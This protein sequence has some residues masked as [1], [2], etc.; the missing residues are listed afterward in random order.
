MRLFDVKNITSRRNPI[1]KRFRQVASGNAPGLLL[2]DGVHLIE[3]AEHA[4]VALRDV[5][6]GP[7]GLDL[8]GVVQLLSRVEAAGVAVWS[9]TDEVIGAI[10]PT[11]SPAGLVALAARPAITLADAF[12]EAPQMVLVAV[13]V[14]DPGN[15]G[16]M[17]R[18]AEA[19]GATA[20]VFA[21]A[22]ADPFGWKALRGSMGSTFRLPVVAATPAQALT[23]ARAAGLRLIATTPR[24]QRS[25]YE[26]DLRRPVA[27][28]VGAEGAGLPSDVIEAADEIVR[29]PM[30]EPVES[31]NVAV[32]AA[33]LVYEASRQRDDT[34]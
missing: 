6:C 18:A 14:Q 2:L 20:A 24:G 12:A 9:V 11:K 4:R 16:A 8:P 22:S 29:I 15:A 27:F 5:A 28:L 23:A 26:M 10:S 17:V 3:A 30:R 13:D 31:L 32:A 34:R 25:L 21:G 33:L 1:V 7:R 19:G